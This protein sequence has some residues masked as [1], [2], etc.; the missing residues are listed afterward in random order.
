MESSL[1]DNAFNADNAIVGIIVLGAVVAIAGLSGCVGAANNNKCLL[2][3]FGFFS[4]VQGIA[5]L[6][7][8]AMLKVAVETVGVSVKREIN[9]ICGPGAPELLMQGLNCTAPLQ[10]VRRL[11]DETLLSES[12]FA[13][14][15]G[16]E[17]AFGSS[18]SKAVPRKLIAGTNE[19]SMIIRTCSR[20]ETSGAGKCDNP[21]Q[22]ISQLCVPPK[23]F[24]PW[25]ACVCDRLGPRGQGSAGVLVPATCSAADGKM[26]EED[27]MGRKLGVFCQ[28]DASVGRQEE[29]CFVLP[30]AKC[31]DKGGTV[32]AQC[33]F[34][35]ETSCKS[36]GPCLD[37]DSRSAFY[38]RAEAIAIRVVGFTGILA[39]L[40]L[41]TGLFS[42]CLVCELQT[43]KDIKDQ[44][45]ALIHDEPLHLEDSDQDYDFQ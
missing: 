13:F 39:V 11:G 15:A 34:A 41:L 38:N 40:A 42:C 33:S 3:S 37:P 8:V 44:T 4:I 25:T 28:A 21:C 7:I 1:D 26:C 30:T 24:D 43:G 10:P 19:E 12:R 2:F 16:M 36:P 14:A 22:L 9:R 32:P 20:M 35:G 29:M 23:D 17:A 27:Q 18:S 45:R 5:L 31:G 6:V